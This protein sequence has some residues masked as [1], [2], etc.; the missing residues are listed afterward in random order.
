MIFLETVIE[1]A[2]L[3]A[4]KEAP[5][6]SCGVVIVHKGKQVFWPCRNTAESNLQFSIHAEDYADADDS[7]K[8]IAIVHSHVLISPEPSQADLVGCEKSKLP[9]LIV[10]FPLGHY[11][12]TEPSGYVAPLVNRPFLHGVFDC[13]SISRDYYQRAL[14][15]ELPEF[16]RR[17]KWWEHGENLFLENFEKAGFVRVDDYRV[18]DGLLMQIRSNVPNHAAILV[19]KGVILHHFA[20]RLSSED[21]YGGWWKKNTTHILRHKSQL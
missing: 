4:A 5:R 8:V 15:L 1:A 20:D 13:Y 16:E 9:W 2:R 11:T 12:V 18:H 14:G 10:N 19:R 7:G 6:E 3:H 17:D 21:V